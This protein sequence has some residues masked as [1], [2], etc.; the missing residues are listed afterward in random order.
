MLESAG[1]LDMGWHKLRSYKTWVM[2][3]RFE[4]VREFKSAW[5]MNTWLSDRD[6]S[7]GWCGRTRSVTS[8][9]FLSRFIGAC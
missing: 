4:D 8:I 1:K 5:P 9:P 2:E 6:Y 3:A 7:V